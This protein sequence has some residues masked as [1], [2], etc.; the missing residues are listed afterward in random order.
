MITFL[1]ALTIRFTAGFMTAFTW[2]HSKG[3]VNDISPVTSKG[4]G[5]QINYPAASG[6]GIK[7]PNKLPLW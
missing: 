7:N 1:I 5:R 2:E 3:I 4:S 6:R